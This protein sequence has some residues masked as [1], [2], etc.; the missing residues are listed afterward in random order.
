MRI[1]ILGTGNV[2]AALGKGWARARHTIAY[3]VRDPGAAKH[4]AAA[5]EAGGAA[6]ASVAEAARGAEVIV[7]AV[8]SDAVGAAVGA[9]GDLSGRIIID[10]T[11]PLRMGAEG[12]ELAIGF[13][14]SAGEQ[15]A[16]LAPRAAVFKTLNQAGSA[17]MADATGY[18]APPVMFVAGDD[19][20]KKPAVMGLVRD[21]GFDAVDAGGIKAARLLEPLAMLWIHMLLNRQAPGDNAFAYLERSKG[22]A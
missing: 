21:L 19:T 22:K 8:P 18:A 3:G 20:A 5:A 14:T 1:A 12:L 2:G 13:S 16:A 9:C 6:V 7:L 4:K 10:P 15:T 11:N 17:V